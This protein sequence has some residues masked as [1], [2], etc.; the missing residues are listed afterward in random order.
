MSKF[1]SLTNR[2]PDQ[3][4]K[5][6]VSEIIRAICQQIDSLSEGRIVANYQ[7]NS[8]APVSVGGAVGDFIKDSSPTVLGTVGAQYIREGWV[9]TSA[10]SSNATWVEKRFMTGT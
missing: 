6:V 7:A 5:S 10:D 3:Y 8:T 2:V 1:I 4:S 9:C